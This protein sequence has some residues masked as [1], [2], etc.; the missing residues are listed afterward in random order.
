MKISG[1]VKKVLLGGAIVAST[2]LPSKL[3]AQ[4]PTWYQAFK[5][6]K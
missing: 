4:T 5:S 3:N 1:L 2:I 6:K